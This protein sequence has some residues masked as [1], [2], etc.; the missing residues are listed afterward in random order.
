MV[1]TL[2]VNLISKIHEVESLQKAHSALVHRHKKD[3]EEVETLEKSNAEFR[4][5]S[6]LYA[7]RHKEAMS[8]NER[9]RKKMSFMGRD[10]RGIE[11]SLRG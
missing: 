5:A 11:V 4:K 10:I 8:V 1:A 6:D 3:V 7:E 9:L 2:K